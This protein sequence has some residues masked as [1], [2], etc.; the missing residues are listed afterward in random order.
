MKRKLTE[1]KGF[2]EAKVAKIQT[3]GKSMV[4]SGFVTASVELARREELI[5][6][7]T[8]A[9][10]IDELLAGGIETGSITEVRM[11]PRLDAPLPGDH[12]LGTTRGER[13]GDLH[14]MVHEGGS[15]S[16]LLHFGCVVAPMCVLHSSSARRGAASLKSVTRFV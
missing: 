16:P 6:I 5:M 12:Y 3:A 13:G 10:A 15:L 1:I 11:G 2:S 8:G 7:T 9:N 4:D 14:V